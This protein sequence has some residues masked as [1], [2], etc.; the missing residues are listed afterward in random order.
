[1]NRVTFVLT[2][3]LTVSAGS[4]LKGAV[5][6]NAWAVGASPRVEVESA[7]R[8]LTEQETKKIEAYMRHVLGNSRIR[9]TRV[10]PDAEVYLDDQFLGVVFP[11]DDKEGRAFYF[12][13]AI[14]EDEIEVFPPPRRYR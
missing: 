3:L 12:E 6:L 14:F 1:M 10:A 4:H 5:P 8:P 13:I 7:A 9:L 2:I 11:D